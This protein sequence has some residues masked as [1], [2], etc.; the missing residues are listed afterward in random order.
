LVV[1]IDGACQIACVVIPHD[2]TRERQDTEVEDGTTF[3]GVAVARSVHLPAAVWH[4]LLSRL[5]STWSA[6]LSIV[7]VTGGRH[8][9]GARRLKHN[10]RNRKSDHSD[11]PSSAKQEQAWIHRIPLDAVTRHD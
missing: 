7:K 4:L 11:P 10:A 8:S 9:P 5:S 6:L 2:D 3:V 1:V